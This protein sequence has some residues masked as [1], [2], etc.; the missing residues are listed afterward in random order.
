MRITVVAKD[1]IRKEPMHNFKFMKYFLF[2][3]KYT[4]KYM[5]RWYIVEMATENIVCHCFFCIIFISHWLSCRT[6]VGPAVRCAGCV[7]EITRL[8]I[9]SYERTY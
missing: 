9:N 5:V 3:F 2:I 7:E 6:A 1:K 8:G 4:K